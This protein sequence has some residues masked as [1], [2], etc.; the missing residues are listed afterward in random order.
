MQEPSLIAVEIGGT[1]LQVCLGRPDGG[2]VETRRGSVDPQHGAPRILEW[3][4]R[5]TKSLLDATGARPKAIGVG[6]GGPVESATGTVLVSH[7]V[8]G[9][10]GFA[11][12]PWFE[13]R[14]GLR[15]IVANDANAAGWAEYCA[16]AGRGTRQFCYMNIGSGIGGA[17]IVDGRLHDGQGRGAN[18]IGHTYVP[19]WTNATPG[20]ADKLEHLCSGWSIEK[21]LRAR[22]DYRPAGPLMRLCNNDASTITCAM[23]AEAAR[24]GDPDALAELDRVAGAVGIALSN[25]ITLFHP[26]RIA[27]GG[28]VSLMGDVLLNPVR[29]HTAKRVFG[30]FRGRYEIVPCALA[31]SVVLAGALLLAGAHECPESQAR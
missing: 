11:L 8:A 21:R 2:I 22:R 5:E 23:L 12:R 16:G 19:D 24:L 15:T 18:E 6:F 31:E 27:M 9:W 3:I 28:G 17:L 10:E 26:E 25:V 4:E 14:F 7:Q 1:K 13:E 29:A 20:A 30:P